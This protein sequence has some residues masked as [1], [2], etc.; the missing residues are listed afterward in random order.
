[1]TIAE[2]LLRQKQDLDDVYQ[3]GY[4]KGATEG[5]GG[6]QGSYDEGYSAGYAAGSF[7]MYKARTIT[8]TSNTFPENTD[9]VVRFENLDG[10]GSLFY[11]TVGLKSVKL[12]YDTEEALDMKQL[13][14]EGAALEL[15]DLTE[16]K[17]RPIDISWFALS[18][19]KLKTILGALDFSECTKATIWLNGARALEDIEFVPNTIGI[20]LDF[21]W[22]Y[23]LSKASLTS[24]VN[25]LS[26]TAEG[27]TVS[28]ST[29]AVNKAFE[30]SE[31]ANDGSTSAE[32]TALANTK[33]NWTIALRDY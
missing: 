19:S 9:L 10:M 7:P 12:I 20:S 27:L 32:W 16:C 13:V 21:Y 1:M 31:G 3:A 11:K 8:F 24:A 2:K 28:F 4:N 30:T 14:R 25:G 5:G 33:T 17:A 29:T 23:N 6:S 22:C 18:S 15:V 26:S